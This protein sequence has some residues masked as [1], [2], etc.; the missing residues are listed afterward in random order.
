MRKRFRVVLVILLIAILAGFAW[1]VLHQHGPAYQGHSLNFW[2][3]QA[4][5][6]NWVDA[7]AENAI[8]AM[9][10]NALPNCQEMAKV[11]D[12][13]LRRGLTEI[14]TRQHWLPIPIRPQHD[15]QWMAYYGFTLLGPTATPAEPALLRL[16]DD[17]DAGVRVCAAICLGKIG[18]TAQDAVPGLIKYLNSALKRDTGNVQDMYEMEAAAFALG[19]IGA[20]A[21]PAIPQ[22]TTLSILTNTIGDAKRICRR[23]L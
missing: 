21:R 19:E 1:L 8:H 7:E 10:T 22:L 3:Q 5:Q 4:Q 12:S 2:L 23:P 14:F 20:S 9:G 18:P 15:I 17:K 13:A 11:R 16:I 6:S